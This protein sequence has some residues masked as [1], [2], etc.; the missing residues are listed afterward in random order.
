MNASLQRAT[1][2]REMILLMKKHLQG[3]EK[4]MRSRNSSG[5]FVRE[6]DEK[7]HLTSSYSHPDDWQQF[8][9]IYEMHCPKIFLRNFTRDVSVFFCLAV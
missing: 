7:S 5:G 6:K 9:N 2:I 8:D 4:E 1:S 3:F